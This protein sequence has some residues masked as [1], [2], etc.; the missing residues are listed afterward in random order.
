M[1]TFATVPTESIESAASQNSKSLPHGVIARSTE[2]ETPASEANP[3]LLLAIGALIVISLIAISGR[4]FWIDE[5]CT[6]MK[7][8]QSTL[9]DWWQVM[10][11]DKTADVQMPLYMFYIWGWGRAFGCG[12]WSLHLANVPWFVLGAAVFIQSFPAGS[13]SRKFAAFAALFCPFA[14]YYLDEARPYAMQLGAALLS[15]GSL[16]YLFQMPDSTEAASGLPLIGFLAGIVILSGSS[17]LGMVWAAAALAAVPLLLSRS[18]ITSLLKQRWEILL[19]ATGPLLLL[20]IYYL[21]TL[22]IG[23]RASASATTT[24]GSIFFAAYELLGFTGLGPGRLEM[25]SAG[26]GA[27]RGHLIGVGLYGMAVALVIGAALMTALGSRTRKQLLLILCCSVPP[28][29]IL[30]VGCVAHFRV[31]GRHLAPFIPVW[32]GLVTVGLTAL[33]TRKNAAGRAVVVVFCILSLLSSLSVRFA[34]RHE[35]DNYRAAAATAQAALRNGQAVW[36]NAAEEGAHY[37]GVPITDHADAGRQA[38]FVMNPTRRTLD[39]LPAPGII[40]A[41]KPDVYDGQN[42]VADYIR[43]HGFAPTAEFA[44]FVIWEKKPK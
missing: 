20:A 28:I 30:A 17:L 43:D 36:W 39:A 22:K 9:T 10:V 21:W 15:V 3:G 38:F 42:A 8:L 25:R 14:W 4:S 19:I 23:A 6:A 7:A 35:K 32:L 33:W 40:V 18:Q 27:L 37:Y 12:E 44:A 24:V 29:F 13:P 1:T 2:S 41:S 34:P 31:L 5:T 11:Q 16:R 26:P